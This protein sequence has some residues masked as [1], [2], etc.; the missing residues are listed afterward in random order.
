MA[1]PVRRR[2]SLADE[3]HPAARSVEPAAP[4]P[5]AP[6]PI[7]DSRRQLNVKV[8]ADL[9]DRMHS[10]FAYA[11]VFEGYRSLTDLVT[12]AVEV[13]VREMEARHNNGNRWPKLAKKGL[14]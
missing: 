10:A 2:S 8:P 6:P 11:G 13:R 5:E 14:S 4:V 1:A 12:D 7:R 3:P 9:L